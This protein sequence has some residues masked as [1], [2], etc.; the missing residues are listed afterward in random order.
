MNHINE[1]MINTFSNVYMWAAI[2][3]TIVIIFIGWLLVKIKIF[4]NEWK[5][6]FISLVLFVAYPALIIKSFMNTTYIEEF[7]IHGITLGLSCAFYIIGALI[8]FIWNRFILNK[9]LIKKKNNNLIDQEIIKNKL[10][11]SVNFWMM[12]IFG[13]TVFFGTPIINALFGDEGL[14]TQIIWNTPFTIGLASFCQFQYF[15][16][17]FSKNNKNKIIKMLLSP[18]VIVSILCLILWIT[19]LIPGSYIKN[20]LSS[21]PKEYIYG[22]WWFDLKYTAP[23]IYKTIDIVAA[24][25]SPLIWIAIGMSIANNKIKSLILDKNSWLFSFIKLLIIPTIVLLVVGGLLLPSKYHSLRELTIIT[26]LMST[27]PATICVAYAIKTNKDINFASNASV[28]STILT[29]IM[30]PI[31]IALSELYGNSIGLI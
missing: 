13:S 18:T 21:Y 31:W 15:N 17:K 8:Y 29:P 5:D 3:A 30:I 28:L 26:I 23:F 7:N 22:V 25:C 1:L 14:M 10:D 2:V 19:Q 9:I 24:L 6:I 20:T 4:K 16:I 11:K 12:S 27:P